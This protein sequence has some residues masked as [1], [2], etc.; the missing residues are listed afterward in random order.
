MSMQITEEK[1]WG[2]SAAFFFKNCTVLV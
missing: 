2:N 1:N